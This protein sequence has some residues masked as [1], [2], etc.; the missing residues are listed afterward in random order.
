MRNCFKKKKK[1]S[2]F[3]FFFLVHLHRFL[4][5]V[6][7]RPHTSQGE[8]SVSL[9]NG[10]R[11]AEDTLDERTDG[12]F[13]DV[14]LFDDLTTDGAR[15]EGEAEETKDA[16]GA[17]GGISFTIFDGRALTTDGDAEAAET[18]HAGRGIN[19]TLAEASL[20]VLGHSCCCLL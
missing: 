2:F 20:E 15:S 12:A 8:F 9:R 16:V 3:F 13:I 11:E 6:T 5:E 4:A 1:K 17:V 18:V 10:A 7:T 14:V 19:H